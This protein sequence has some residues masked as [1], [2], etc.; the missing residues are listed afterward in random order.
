MVPAVKCYVCPSLWGTGV[1][2]VTIPVLERLIYMVLL[3][4]IFNHRPN[5][6]QIPDMVQAKVTTYVPA[7]PPNTLSLT[8]PACSGQRRILTC[9]LC[10]HVCKA[11]HQQT[12][13]PLILELGCIFL[14]Q[15]HHIRV[16]RMFDLTWSHEVHISFFSI[17]L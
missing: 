17:Q 16:S 13:G 14:S 12:K 9:D 4:Y 15:P 3:V 7:L 11:Y 8:T 5:L 1:A 10:F 2:A 6:Y